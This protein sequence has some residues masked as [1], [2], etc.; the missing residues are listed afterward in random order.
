MMHLVSVRD[1][2]NTELAAGY[3]DSLLRRITPAYV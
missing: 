1:G 3:Y 2:S